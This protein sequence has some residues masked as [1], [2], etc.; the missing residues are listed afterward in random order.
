MDIIQFA[1]WTF[2]KLMGIQSISSLGILLINL[3]RMF[4]IKI[5]IFLINIKL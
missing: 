3:L 2:N 1:I 5:R 4:K